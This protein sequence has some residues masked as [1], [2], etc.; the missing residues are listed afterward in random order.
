MANPKPSPKSL[1]PYRR[2]QAEA[3]R[4]LRRILEASAKAIQARVARLPQGVGGQVRAAQLRL[5]LTAIRKLQRSMWTGAVNSTVVGGVDGAEKAAESAIETMTRVAYAS[6]PEAAAEAL[7][8]GLRLSAESGLK[9]DAARRKRELST[10]VYRQAALHEGKVEDIIRQ[11]LVSNLSA[12]ELASDVYKYVS[13]TTPGGASYAAMRLA[14]TEINNA[15]HE[16]QLA[17]AKRP[18]VTAVKWNLSGSHRVPDLCNVY[19]GHG[20]NG[21]WKPDSVPDKPHPQCFCFLTYVTAPPDEFRKR[22]EAGSFDDEIDRRTRENMARVGQK[23]GKVEPKKSEPTKTK[24]TQTPAERRQSTPKKATPKKIATPKKTV[25]PE[26]KVDQPPKDKGYVPGAWVLQTDHEAQIQVIEANLRKLTPE[27]QHAGLRKIAEEFVAGTIEDTDLE[28]HNGPHIVRFTGEL[29]EEQRNTFLGYVDQLQTAAPTGRNMHIVIAP[30]ADFGEGVGGE[31][32]L[33]TGY[34]RI[35]DKTLKQSIWPGMPVSKDVPSA[36]YVL[37]HE[38][39]HSFPNKE[40]ARN[41]DAH[42]HAVAAGGMT[43]YGTAG[44][45]GAEGHAAEGYAEA[46]A[47]WLLSGGKTTNKAA[48]SYAKQ[49]EWGERFGIH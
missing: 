49:F 42:K 23:V 40:E 5:T 4:D 17:G 31:T 27:D 37:A 43:R 22:L 48:Q 28:F 35:N 41:T 47:E 45:T 26:P 36:L 20:G 46:F 15:F 25:V 1:Q 9:S 8:R 39:G 16:R 12:K 6:L 29:T 11:G 3:E 30:S 38:W 33:A 10:R 34:M 2:V 7:V 19:A 13:P 21:E 32:T 18:G 24:P 14:R 44:G